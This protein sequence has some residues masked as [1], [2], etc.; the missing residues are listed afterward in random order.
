MQS[1]VRE[2]QKSDLRKVSWSLSSSSYWVFPHRQFSSHLSARQGEL[3]R[4]TCLESVRFTWGVSEVPPAA[5]TV[6]L[7]SSPCGFFPI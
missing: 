5:L 4:Q 7:L 2:H 3:G 1:Q 6:G